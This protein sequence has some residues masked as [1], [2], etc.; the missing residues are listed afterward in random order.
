MM[1]KR[2]NTAVKVDMGT[3]KIQAEIKYLG[4]KV[5]MVGV[6]WEKC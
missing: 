1:R 2:I 4:W 5:K 6:N 3:K